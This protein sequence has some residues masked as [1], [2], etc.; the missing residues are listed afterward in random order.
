MEL[1]GNTSMTSILEEKEVELKKEKKEK[2]DIYN[3][4]M[5]LFQ[6]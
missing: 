3:K 4:L 5:K 2:E 1:F 6:Q